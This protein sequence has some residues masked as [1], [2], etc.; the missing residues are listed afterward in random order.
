MGGV[1]RARP[2]MPIHRPLVVAPKVVPV[3]F[4]PAVMPIHKPPM[5]PIH[6]P[7]VIPVAKVPMV[8]AKPGMLIKPGIARPIVYPKPVFRA[9]PNTEQQEEEADYQE[10]EVAGEEQYCEYEGEEAQEEEAQG[11]NLR[12]RPMMMVPPPRHMHP[13]RMMPMRPVVPV[14]PPMMHPRRGPMM[15]YNTFQP[16]I[17]RARPRPRVVPVP[18]FTPLNTTF[19]P[20]VYGGFGMRGPRYGPMPPMRP[21]HLFRGKERS[22]SYDD[23]EEQDYG[24]CDQQCEQQGEQ[25][26][27]QQ[28]DQQ[29]DQ[30]CTKSV[31]TK[32]GK[33]F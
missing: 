4:K 8:P 33:E 19:Q 11:E 28:C 1:F 13:P 32:C 10:E 9:R 17:F 18:M 2:G 16:R 12:H 26:C 29:C 22:N 5:M 27:E 24:E 30:Q 25:Q 3:P 21:H 14:V 31:C 20:R 7:P 15:G 6:K 23:A